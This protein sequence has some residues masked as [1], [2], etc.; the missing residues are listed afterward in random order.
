LVFT[1]I[2]KCKREKIFPYIGSKIKGDDRKEDFSKCSEVIDIA[3]SGFY[4][5]CIHDKLMFLKE[6]KSPLLSIK[7]QMYLSRIMNEFPDII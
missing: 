2:S 6:P 7:K 5:F 4:E 1:G 3:F